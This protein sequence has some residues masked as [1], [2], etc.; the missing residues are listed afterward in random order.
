MSIA[1]CFC[2]LPSLTKTP[3]LCMH[4]KKVSTVLLLWLTDYKLLC[5]LVQVSEYENLI[6]ETV[7][8]QESD[9]HSSENVEFSTEGLVDIERSI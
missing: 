7:V 2:A 1:C 3:A 5:N 6:G 4:S 9:L 8:K